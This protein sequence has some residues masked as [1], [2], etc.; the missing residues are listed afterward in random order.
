MRQMLPC[1]WFGRIKGRGETGG[2]GREGRGEGGLSPSLGLAV[3]SEG[4]DG[5]EHS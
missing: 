3:P 2:Q 5:T 1:F 4:R